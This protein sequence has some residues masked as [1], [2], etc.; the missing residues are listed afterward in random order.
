MADGFKRQTA[1]KVKVAS[2]TRGEWVKKEGMEPSFVVTPG[3]EQV[4]R[5]RVMG[6]VVAKFVAEDENFASM[7]LDDFSDTIRAKAF[8]EVKPLDRAEVGDIVDLIGKVRE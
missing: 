3:G 1:K 8:K 5:A 4:S 2:L 7:T 6:T